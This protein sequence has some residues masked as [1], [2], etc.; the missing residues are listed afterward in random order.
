M[1]RLA[2]HYRWSHHARQAFIDLPRREVK[3]VFLLMLCLETAMAYGGRIQVA[4]TDGRWLVTGQANK[5]RIDADL[6]ETLSNPMAQV[7]MSASRVHFALVPE[8]VARQG[9]RLTADIRETEIRLDF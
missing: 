9:R 4:H 3:L 8:E 5:M 2:G 7:E 1:P 6:W